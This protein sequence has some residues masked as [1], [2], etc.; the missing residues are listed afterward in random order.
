MTVDDAIELARSVDIGRSR[1]KMAEAEK[2]ARDA[3][4]RFPKSVDLLT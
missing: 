3:L 4:E 2:A 1:Y